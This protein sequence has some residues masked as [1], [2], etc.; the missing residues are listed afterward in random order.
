M[1][2][3][4]IQILKYLFFVSLGLLLLYFAFR[5]IDFKSVREGL[6]GANYSWVLLSLI[7]SIFA[8]ISRARRWILL[9]NPLGYNPSL[10][11]SFLAMMTGYLANIAFPRLGEVTK[12]VALG[13]KEKIPVDQLV[14]TV[15]V[16]RTIDFL[17]LLVIMTIMLF[18]S[19]NTIGTFLK[20]NI[21]VPTQEKIT[22]MFGFTYIFWLVILIFLSLLVSTFIKFRKKIASVKLVTKILHFSKG[23]VEGIKSVIKLE[24]KKEFLFHTLFIWSNY[25]LMTWVV[26]FS[27]ASTSGLNFTDAVFL[28]VIGSLAMSAPV[29]SGIGAFHWIISRGLNIVYGIKLEDGLVYAIISHETQLILVTIIGAIS[30]AILFNKHKKSQEL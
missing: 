21:I 9:I 7:F 14:G 1:K 2:K 23:I 4:L 28:L 12:C 8:F 20:N 10:K 16:E 24:R 5:N 29:Q 6:L 19:S 17:S 13:K 30:F 25:I 22:S 18:I 3:S 11:N 15:I 26:L 27:V